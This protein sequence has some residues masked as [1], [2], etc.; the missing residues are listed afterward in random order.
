MAGL[1]LLLLLQLL[2]CQRQQPVVVLSVV[3]LLTGQLQVPTWCVVHSPV[4]CLLYQAVLQIS[5]AWL[6]L[7]LL[8]CIRLALA[9]C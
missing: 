1:P 9:A 7:L 4:R 3:L 8:A 6:A 2:L 5:T